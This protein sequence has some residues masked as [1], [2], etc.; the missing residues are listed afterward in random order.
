MTDLASAVP[1]RYQGAYIHPL[2]VVDDTNTIGQGTKIWSG[3]LVRNGTVLGENVSVGVGCALEGCEIGDDTHLNPHVLAGVGL[4][5]GKRCFLGGHVVLCNDAHPSVSREANGGWHPSPG[6]VT[7]RVGD[8]TAICTGAI[9]LPGVT[10]GNR[11]L[12]A[13]GAVCGVDVPDDHM[14][15]R[16]GR[17]KPVDVSRIDRMRPI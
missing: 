15:L 16:D 12:I 17:I 7:V 3:A 10:I 11:C 13:A 5:V 6:F 4:V 9:I 14:F 2:A 8:D 1:L